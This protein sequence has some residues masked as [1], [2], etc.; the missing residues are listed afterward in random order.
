MLIVPQNYLPS[1]PSRQTI[2]QVRLDFLN[3]N[4][5]DQFT[6]GT[7]QP[8]CML[9]MSSVAPDL[10]SFIGEVKIAKYPYDPLNTIETNPG[11]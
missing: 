1:D 4:V 7:K 10:S 2:H 6:F 8:T 11:G 5:T 9:D 3:A